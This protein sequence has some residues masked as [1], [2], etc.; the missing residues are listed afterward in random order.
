[1]PLWG[2]HLTG[3]R[4]LPP[5][6]ARRRSLQAGRMS[7]LSRRLGRNSPWALGSGRWHSDVPLFQFYAQ[8]RLNG[9]PRRTD[10][11]I[12]RSACPTPQHASERMSRARARVRLGPSATEKSGAGGGVH[13][14]PGDSDRTSHFDRIEPQIADEQ[15]DI[16]TH[17]YW[18]MPI[19]AS[20]RTACHG[21]GELVQK[22]PGRSPFRQADQQ[23]VG[24]GN[25]R[26][27]LPGQWLDGGRV[28]QAHFRPD[29]IN[30]GL[31]Q[32]ARNDENFRYHGAVTPSAW[33]T[34][35]RLSGDNH[36][37]CCE[38]EEGYG[39]KSCRVG[40]GQ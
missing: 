22:A 24:V 4:N 1:M 8:L 27:G 7:A 23:P 11:R 32:A 15:P 18:P 31:C 35:Y 19:G 39:G 30:H 10:T 2:I 34:P 6:A 29:R 37:D 5:R 33:L 25:G 38:I 12:S 36:L 3:V 16:N 14:D 26:P 9:Y 20:V 28:E 13:R 40:A 21:M 17:E